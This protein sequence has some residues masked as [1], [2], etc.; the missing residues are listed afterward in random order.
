VRK[1]RVLEQII[2]PVPAICEY[3]TEKKKDEVYYTCERDE[4]NRKVCNNWFLLN[5]S[6]FNWHSYIINKIQEKF[7]LNSRYSRKI[8]L[9]FLI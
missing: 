9:L 8:K 6:I 1:D 4:H 7:I 3:L 5:K 2:F